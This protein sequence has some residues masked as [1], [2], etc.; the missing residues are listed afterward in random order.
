MDD[1]VFII[2]ELPDVR[3]EFIKLCIG[4]GLIGIPLIFLFIWCC[5]L[6]VDKNLDYWSS[7]SVISGIRE[8]V[9]HPLRTQFKTISNTTPDIT[10]T[11]VVWKTKKHQLNNTFYSDLS[12]SKQE[13]RFSD[14]TQFIGNKNFARHSCTCFSLIKCDSW[15]VY[16]S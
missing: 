5:D 9:K 7:S 12:I 6:L 13:L 16:M 2:L 1:P 3:N 8:C 14:W 11:S 4:F 15:S 10:T